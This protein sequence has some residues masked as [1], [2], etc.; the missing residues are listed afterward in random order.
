M[1][2]YSEIYNVCTCK[3]CRFTHVY[4]YMY[5]YVSLISVGRTILY[6]FD[7][8]LQTLRAC[9]PVNVCIC[10]CTCMCIMVHIHVLLASFFHTQ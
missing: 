3:I 9:V 5:M 6:R 4:M 7:V 10:T 8:I 1:Y 2:M